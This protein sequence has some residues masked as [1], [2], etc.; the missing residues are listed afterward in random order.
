MIGM[1]VKEADCDCAASK[2]VASDW[3]QFALLCLERP[4]ALLW[5]TV[6]GLHLIAHG[7]NIAL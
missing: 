4:L 5:G 1:D 3:P 6:A 2:S 7:K